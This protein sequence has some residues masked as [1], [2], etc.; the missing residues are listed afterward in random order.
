MNDN[1]FPARHGGTPIAGWLFQG[2]SHLEMDDLA[3]PLC[4][5]TPDVYG[6]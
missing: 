6:T 4:Q 1:G 5:E 2:I 3:V